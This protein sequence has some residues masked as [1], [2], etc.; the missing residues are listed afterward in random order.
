MITNFVA[1]IILA[2]ITTSYYKAFKDVENLMFQKSEFKTKG[3]VII[4]L[5]LVA[6]VIGVVGL[7]LQEVIFLGI[8]VGTAIF[9]SMFLGIFSSVFWFIELLIWVG[10]ISKAVEEP[11]RVRKAGPN[12]NAQYV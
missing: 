2:V 6:L 9:G 7:I 10:M 12:N 11:S 1:L 3:T 4:T 5:R 8:P